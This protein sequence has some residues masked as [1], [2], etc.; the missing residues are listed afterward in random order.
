M[1]NQFVVRLG[2]VVIF[3]IG[4]TACQT[5]PYQGDRGRYGSNGCD[6]SDYYYN[7]GQQA[8]AIGETLSV[9][10]GTAI[11]IIQAI[12]DCG[13]YSSGYYGGRRHHRGYGGAYYRNGRGGPMYRNHQVP[14]RYY[15]NQGG[16]Y[17]RPYP[18]GSRGCGNQSGYYRSGGGEYGSSSHGRSGHSS[19]D[20]S[21]CE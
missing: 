19:G 6:D 8:A 4:L 21:N 7:N 20:H 18:V 12:A 13:G 17:I 1:K 9:V 11:P 2:L 14:Y 15:G 10:A 3:G 16:R 5:V